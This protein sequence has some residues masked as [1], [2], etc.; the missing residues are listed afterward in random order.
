MI[1]MLNKL[2]WKQFTEQI[3][4][5]NSKILKC[6]QIFYLMILAVVQKNLTCVGARDASDNYRNLLKHK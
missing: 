5:N 1:F 6:E 3:E 2:Y 4:Y